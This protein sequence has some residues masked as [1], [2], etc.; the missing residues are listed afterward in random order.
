[1]ANPAQILHGIFIQWDTDKIASVSRGLKT[2][3]SSEFE[4]SV[5]RLRFAAMQLTAIEELLESMRANGIDV[6][7]WDG[8]L[9]RWTQ[10]LFLFPFGW[11][12]R[13]GLS[14]DVRDIEMLAALGDVLQYQIP[15]LKSDGAEEI[16][17]FI[18]RLEH[19]VSQ[20]KMNEH[21]R[22]HV[23][24]IVSHIRWCITNFEFVGEFE[25]EKALQQLAASVCLQVQEDEQTSSEPS[26]FREFMDSW[27]KPFTVGALAGYMGNLLS[28]GT[29]AITH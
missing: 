25:L 15:K 21:L 17:D 8:P 1:M 22:R 28:S 3:G 11:D 4:S 27:V 6:S 13:Q 14:L 2:G 12:N 20:E 23:V 24:N 18:D 7:K 29:L 9:S 26:K 10:G 19:T 16:L 5:Q